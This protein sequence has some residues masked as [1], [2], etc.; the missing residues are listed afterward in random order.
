L[1]RFGL[2]P[3]EFSDLV[4]HFGKRFFTAA[5]CPASLDDEASRR[6]KQ[7]L[8]GPGR[9]ALFRSKRKAAAP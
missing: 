6:G 8:N 9:H 1:S 5:G 4:H 2:D 7:R 3:T